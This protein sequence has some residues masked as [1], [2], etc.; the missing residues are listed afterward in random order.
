VFINAEAQEAVPLS[1]SLVSLLLF[2]V[3]G[4]VVFLFAKR[5]KRK[6]STRGGKW[7]SLKKK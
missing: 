6:L 2:A 3:I 5:P 4:L 1:L 7:H